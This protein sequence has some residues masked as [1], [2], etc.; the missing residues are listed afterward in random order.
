MEDKINCREALDFICGLEDISDLSALNEKYERHLKSC[1]KC[2][3]YISSLNSTIEL[4][5]SYNVKLPTDI[6]KKIL[7]N[8]CCKLKSV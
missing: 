1:K 2:Q 8:V 5:R 3:S 7:N 6:Q 4:Y